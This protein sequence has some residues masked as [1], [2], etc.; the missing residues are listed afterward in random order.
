MPKSPLKKL[1][2]PNEDNKVL[3]GYEMLGRHNK[4]SR[5]YIRRCLKWFRI[6]F[7]KNDVIKV[8]EM[9]E[10]YHFDFETQPYVII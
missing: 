1:L 8:K 10:D 3:L 9:P 6:D 5:F 7:K 2:V 4:P